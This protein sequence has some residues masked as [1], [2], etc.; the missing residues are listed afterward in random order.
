MGK[1]TF[2]NRITRTRDALVD[3][4]PGV[5]RDRHIG[6]AEWNDTG[7]TLVDTGG[8]A[9]PGDDPFA[10]SIRLQI[11]AAIDEA[12]AVVMLF[13]GRTGVAPHDREM[14]DLLRRTGKP[15]HYAV[16]KIDDA[17]QESALA[18]FYSLG[19]DP[20][21]PI[22]AEHRYGITDFLD[23]LTEG[24]RSG[25]PEPEPEMIRVAVVGRPN[26]GKSSLINRMIGRE[27]HLV[28]DIPGT[29]RDA[30]DSI[31]RANGKSYLMVDTA[32]IRRK[33][34][35]SEKIEKISIIKAL[36]SLVRCDVALI[37]IDAA[38]GITE[39]DINVA[40]Y[41]NDKGCG[42]VFLLN[43]WDL[44]EKD[45]RTVERFIEELHDAA[46]F[47]AFAPAVTVSALTGQRIGRI[48]E[49]VEAVYAQYASRIATGPLNRIL[50]QAVQANEPPYHRGRRL[51]FY[52]ATQAG[53]RPP[54]F[55]VFVNYP[56]AVH[57][58]YQRYLTNRIR[59]GAGLDKTPLR[60]SL[61][62][63]SG[64]IGFD[65]KPS[66]REDRLRQRSPS[67]RRQR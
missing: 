13:D 50:E 17:P 60:L 21:F 12:D 26:V 64:R 47:L 54:S 53:S 19:L 48:F 16:N 42:V 23:H 56:E 31:C 63:R 29:T 37:V 45:H 8:F 27:R 67:R 24:F 18:E 36:L 35:V 62:E 61:R 14:V 6:D 33:G 25:V 51:K 20:I 10:E 34:K 11:M 65:D 1:S 4:F 44:V 9:G 22:S 41:A 30:I 15:V 38:E 3:D 5:T 32:G 2:F 66:K 43:K 58:S 28:S 55:V 46:K 49:L 39:Q 7:F 52:Y 59:E 40:G 57:F